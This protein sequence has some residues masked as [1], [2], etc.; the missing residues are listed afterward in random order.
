MIQL[1]DTEKVSYQN[2]FTT[3]MLH[4]KNS[5]LKLF[6]LYTEDAYVDFYSPKENHPPVLYD[7]K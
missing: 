2:K 5:L 4:Y 6:L 1:N 7:W 3:Y